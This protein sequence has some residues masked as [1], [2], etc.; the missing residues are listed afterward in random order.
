MFVC[1]LQDVGQWQ[2]VCVIVCF[3]TVYMLLCYYCYCYATVQHLQDV[4]YVDH[5][6]FI[7]N[8]M[9]PPDR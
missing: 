4:F 5:A 2:C 1:L 6:E 9:T 7:C 3:Y 8:E